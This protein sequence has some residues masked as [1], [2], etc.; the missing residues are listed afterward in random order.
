V[1]AR[2]RGTACLSRRPGSL[3]FLENLLLAVL[4]HLQ[5]APNSLHIRMGVGKL[6]TSHAEVI[7]KIPYVALNAEYLIA[8]LL[9][10]AYDRN[11][12]SEFGLV[13]LL[14]TKIGLNAQFFHFRTAL[15][16]GQKLVVG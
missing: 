9:A 3:F 7:L 12:A 8:L 15:R 5:L 14:D 6:L 16:V 2:G 11:L 1:F 13:S 4:G 10:G